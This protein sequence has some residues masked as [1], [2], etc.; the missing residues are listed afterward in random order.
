M[1]PSSRTLVRVRCRS[2]CAHMDGRAQR[3]DRGDREEWGV[4]WGRKR[5]EMS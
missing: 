3:E 1:D 4:G 5:A 2:G